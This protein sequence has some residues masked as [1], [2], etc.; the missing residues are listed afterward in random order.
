MIFIDFRERSVCVILSTMPAKKLL[1]SQQ[2]IMLKTVEEI[3]QPVYMVGGCVRDILLGKSPND[4]DFTT[5]LPPDE[6]E[7]AVRRAGLK[8][9]ISGKRFGTI[10]CRI[11]NQHVEITTFR[12][13]KYD[14]KSRKPKVEFVD[15]I[16]ADLARRDFTINAMAI[17][18][19]THLIDPFGGLEDLKSGIVRAVNKPH[20]RFHED[21]LRMLRA[22]RFSTQ[23]D[24]SIDHETKAAAL[25]IA[26][27]ILRVSKERWVRELDLM[28]G[29]TKPS[30]GLRYLSDTRLLVYMLPEL[31]MQVDFDQDSPYH[32]LNLWEHSLKT[33]D[34]SPLDIETR[35]AALLHDIGK[36]YTR[37]KN[38]RGYSNYVNHD[39]VGSEMVWKIGKYLRWGNHRLDNVT[40]VVRDHLSD[41][42]SPIAEADSA[43]R[44]R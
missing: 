29:S 12:T 36:P 25:K 40:K 37:T 41:D 18:E 44:H 32:E 24:F 39:L 21:P 8:A 26:P 6:I 19:P 3:L 7:Q 20:E 10:G 23:L 22:G 33:V 13:E 30:I 42:K 11:N 17:R 1:G 27:E 2:L 38:K 16:T 43:S 5:P 15:D 9:H 35:W 4:Y 28:L 34:L 31:S 14:G